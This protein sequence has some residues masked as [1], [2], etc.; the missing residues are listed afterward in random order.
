MLGHF[1]KDCPKRKQWFERKGKS[2]I[3]GYIYVCM[4]R[5]KPN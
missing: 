5:I 1:K 3:K 4:F 2:L